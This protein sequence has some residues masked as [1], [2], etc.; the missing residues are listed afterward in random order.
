MQRIL[1]KREKV[2]LCLTVTL[3]IFTAGFNL[4]IAPVLRKSDDL[5]SEIAL[6]KAKLNRYLGLLSQREYIEQKYGEFAPGVNLSPDGRQGR[7]GVLSE[8]ETLAEISNIRIIDL[9]PESS[10][11][12]TSHREIDISLRTEGMMEEYLRFIYDIESSPFLLRI[13]KLQ[14]NSRPHSPLLEGIFSVSQSPQENT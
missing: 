9:R 10:P 14:L 13:K 1:N 4:L 12:Q 8:L 2:F 3:I 6:N 11:G 7:A 5:N